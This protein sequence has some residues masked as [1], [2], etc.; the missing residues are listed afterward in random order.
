MRFDSRRY[1]SLTVSVTMYSTVA[2]SV[3][4]RLMRA[5]SGP[6]VVK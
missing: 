2:T 3:T 1:A 5:S 6:R 4:M